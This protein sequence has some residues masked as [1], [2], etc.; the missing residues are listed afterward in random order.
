VAIGD[1]KAVIFRG[2]RYKFEYDRRALDSLLNCGFSPS[3][4]Q[5]SISKLGMI[6]KIEPMDD[7][8]PIKRLF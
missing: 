8:L 5:D 1:I 6:L 4:E 2:T 3:P 7:P